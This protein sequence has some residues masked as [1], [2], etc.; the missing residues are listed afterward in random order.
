M[1]TSSWARQVLCL[2]L[3]CV[4]APV[5]LPAQT[6]TTLHNFDGSD[7]SQAFGSLIQASNGN[8]Y[9]TTYS[10]GEN[11]DGTVFEMTPAGTLVTLHSFDVTDGSFPE[12]GLVA[13]ANGDLYGT[14]YA[15]GSNL[16]GTMFEI[17]LGGKLTKLHS[18]G[19]YKDGAEPFGALVLGRDGNFYGTTSLGGPYGGGT[20]FKITPEGTVTT[21]HGFCAQIANNFCVDGNG[22]QGG[23]V[24]GANGNFYGTT[25]AGGVNDAGAIFEVTPDGAFTNLHSFIGMGDDPDGHQPYAGLVLASNGNF[26][27]TT[28]K[29]GKYLDGT[30]FEMTPGGTLTTLHDFGG[31]DG[32]NP[33]AGLVQAT[34]GNLYG[35]TLSGGIY[36]EGTIFEITLT[37]VFTKRHSFDALNGDGANPFAGLVQ[38]KDGNLYGTTTGRGAYGFGTAFKFSLE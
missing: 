11:R 10:G 14:T 38:G 24:Q 35:V 16:N 13:G 15:G 19:R 3:S 31:A 17:T 27:G 29:G 7:G 36:G 28:I 30:I 23:L 34:N 1:H 37:G 2:F 5:A 6:L 8:F 21:L 18:F 12:A 25:Y 33:W 9:G 22:P 26:Y 32:A 20:V 4:I